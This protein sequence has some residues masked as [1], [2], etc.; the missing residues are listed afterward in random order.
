MEFKCG[1]TI[2]FVVSAF[3]ITTRNAGNI[4]L[5]KI[6]NTNTGK[7]WEISSKSAIK[8]TEEWQ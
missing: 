7:R 5:F 8:T 2:N 1:Q 4:Y 6:N 3:L